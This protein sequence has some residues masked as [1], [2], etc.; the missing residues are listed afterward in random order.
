M[1]VE[2]YLEDDMQKAM[3]RVRAELGKDAVLISSRR[4]DGRTEVMAASDCDPKQL[5]AEI[6]KYT[7]RK[8]PNVSQKNNRDFL[9]EVLG[10]KKESP[11]ESVPWKSVV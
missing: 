9:F 6:K 3:S 7:A 4:V 1:R 11:T 2:S 8:S 10:E 5:E